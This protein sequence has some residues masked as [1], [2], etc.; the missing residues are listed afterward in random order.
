M[1]YDSTVTINPSELKFVGT[2]IFRAMRDEQALD[3]EVLS[4]LNDETRS[5]SV[6]ESVLNYYVRG[7][8]VY[9]QTLKQSDPKWFVFR[10]AFGDPGSGRFLERHAWSPIIGGI[11]S[12]IDLHKLVVLLLDHAPTKLDRQAFRQFW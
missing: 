11:F 2:A 9:L 6:Y 7:W 10:L 3:S 1:N 12:E 8:S 4:A 5:G